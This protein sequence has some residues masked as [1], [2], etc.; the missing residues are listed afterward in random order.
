MFTSPT[1]Y[2]AA[3]KQRWGNYSQTSLDP[4]NGKS[5]WM[6]NEKINAPTI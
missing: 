2:G 1:F 5:A 3:G 6:V 4:L